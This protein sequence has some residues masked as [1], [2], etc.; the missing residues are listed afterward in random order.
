LNLSAHSLK[1]SLRFFGAEQGFQLAYQLELMG[2]KGDF[3][4]AADT[5]NSLETVLSQLAPALRAHV[6]QAGEN[7]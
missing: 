3:E 6:K 7:A 5:L 1:G 4:K 2:R